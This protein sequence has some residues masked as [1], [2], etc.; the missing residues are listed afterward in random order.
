MVFPVFIFLCVTLP[1]YPQMSIWPVT[2]ENR[3]TEAKDQD[4]LE[5]EED[6]LA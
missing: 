5:E 3:T 4:L 2:E 6:L 1:F